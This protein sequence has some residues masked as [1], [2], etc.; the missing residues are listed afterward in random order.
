MNTKTILI[1]GS[2]SGIG[3]EAARKLAAKPEWGIIVLGARSKAKAEAARD[4]IMATTGRSA[5]DFRNLIV[6]LVDPASVQAAVQDVA[7][8]GLRFDAVVLNAGGMPSANGGELQKVPSGQSKLFAMNVGGHAALVNGLLEGGHFSEHATVVFAASEASRGIPMMMAK[9][10][11]LP[12]GYADVDAALDAIV[13]GDHVQK[14]DDMYEYG[15]VKLL[16]AVWMTEL[17]HRHPSSLRAIAVSPGMTGGT[18]AM[19]EM[20]SLMKTMMT[21]VMLPM[22][23]LFGMAHKVGNGAD[24]YLQAL[25][26]ESLVNGG[27]YASPGSKL[28]GPLTLQSTTAQ[29]LLNDEPFIRA[30]GRLM[31]RLPQAPV[32]AK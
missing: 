4:N 5:D 6:D 23:S 12:D 20:P 8:Q 16:G 3:L 2:N 24:R 10:A 22:M 25:E 18:N 9:A 29:P 30:V 28:T 26:D 11:K 32:A 31:D 17:A 15:L 13:T 14:V 19:A 7:Q 21:W 1:T 27:F